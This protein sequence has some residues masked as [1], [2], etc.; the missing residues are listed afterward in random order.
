VTREIDRRKK[1]VAK[2]LFDCGLCG[3]LRRLNQFSLKLG[4][5]LLQFVEE[6]VRVGPVEADLGCA[7]AQLARLQ[8]RRHGARNVVQQGALRRRR[9]LLL[10]A[11]DLLPVPQ[12]GVGVGGL[13]SRE[14]VR[15][16]ADEFGVQVLRDLVDG[17]VAC[18][19]GHLRVE[20]H[21]Q[22]QV[23]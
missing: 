4:D 6:A 12:N 3:V 13:Y 23:A 22:Q 11:L 7:G 14:D 2:L 10:D 8:H 9:G 15:V 16:A 1:Q 19:R 17:E 5:L 21:L 18:L 20:E